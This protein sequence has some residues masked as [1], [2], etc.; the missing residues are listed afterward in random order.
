MTAK[1]A[2][3]NGS[4]VKGKDK[5]KGKGG[6]PASRPSVEELRAEM[7]ARGLTG[8]D[9]VDG[10]VVSEDDDEIAPAG[11]KKGRGKA[12]KGKKGKKGAQS[13]DII[14]EP[15]LIVADDEEDAE[16]V[17]EPDVDE[18]VVVGAEV[19]VVVPPGVVVVDATATKKRRKIDPDYDL[20]TEVQKL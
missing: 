6:K 10:V 1:A 19:E 17:E 5:S 12:T 15:D 8:D 14:D 16:E 7:E 20:D 11:G 9:D 18:D 13:G 2:S 4:A 3:T